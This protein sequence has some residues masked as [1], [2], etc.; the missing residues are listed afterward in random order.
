LRGNAM[1]ESEKKHTQ[2][3]DSESSSHGFQYRRAL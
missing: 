1:R 3:A 2:S